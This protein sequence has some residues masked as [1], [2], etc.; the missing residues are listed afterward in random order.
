MHRRILLLDDDPSI[1]HALM[2]TLHYEGYEIISANSGT[3]ALSLLE[4]EG[5]DLIVSDEKMPGLS[6]TDF[7]AIV[8]QRYPDVIR[9]ILTGHA[10]L[11]SAMRAINEGHIYRFFTKPWN[12]VDLKITIRQAL[13][14]KELVEEN[15][16]LLEKVGQQMTL[17]KK[18]EKEYPGIGDVKRDSSGTVIIDETE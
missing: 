17:L 18:L 3:E 5:V 12:E 2:R 11:E 14:Q 15:R 9:I 8:S 10:T 7:F 13:R 4:N 1:I 16:E 6:G